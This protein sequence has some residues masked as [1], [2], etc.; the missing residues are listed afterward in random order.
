MEKII[1]DIIFWAFIFFTLELA[2]KEMLPKKIFVVEDSRQD[3]L[4]YKELFK[5]E[6]VRASFFGNLQS[7]FCAFRFQRPDAVIIDYVLPDGYSDKL[8]KECRRL[9]I[10]VIIVTSCDSVNGIDPSNVIHKETDFT[11]LNKIKHWLHEVA[12]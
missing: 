6:R 11:H 1:L 8:F 4:L 10:P 12:A 5:H 2:L 3:T 7:I 9:G